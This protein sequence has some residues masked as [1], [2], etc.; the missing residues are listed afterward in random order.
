[1]RSNMLQKCGLPYALNWE[2]CAPAH[3]E[4]YATKLLRNTLQL[5]EWHQVGGPR[6][7]CSV[8]WSAARCQCALRTA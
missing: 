2:T 8:A 6:H 4:S 7:T 5:R 3:Y 1:M